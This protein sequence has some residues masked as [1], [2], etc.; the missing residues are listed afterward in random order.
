ME[1][2]LKETKQFLE[3]NPADIAKD[4]FFLID[5]TIIAQ[6]VESAHI[7]HADRVLEVGPGL[8]FITRELAQQ[9]AE[10]VSIEIDERFKP[11]LDTL[12]SNV[13]IV[14]GNAYQLINNRSFRETTKPFTKVVASIP[15]SQAQNMLHN[16]TNYA[17]YQGD[18]V[19]LA[20]KSLAEKVNHEPILGAFF[21]AHIIMDVPKTAFYPQPNTTSAI[22]CFKRTEDPISSNNFDLYLRQYL[23]NHE[24]VKVK[25]AVRE[26]IIDA[27]WNLKHK[28]ITKKQARELMTR[29]ALPDEELEKLTYNIK[30]EYYFAI[31]NLLTSWFNGI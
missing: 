24:H 30:P 9:A 12:P 6:L 16:Y 17:W 26:G 11:V 2:L 18:L 28:K 27:A 31:P 19:W 3:K 4:Q 15:Y 14:Y 7:T 23:Y 29:L 8:G 13:Q 21:T 5:P 20:P 10:V 22:I 1:Q 25:N